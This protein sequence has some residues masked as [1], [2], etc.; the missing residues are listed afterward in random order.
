MRK[1]T[2]LTR[3]RR[4]GTKVVAQSPVIV[5]IIIVVHMVVIAVVLKT[6]GHNK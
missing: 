4:R 5:G 1:L 2:V 3:G 6:V